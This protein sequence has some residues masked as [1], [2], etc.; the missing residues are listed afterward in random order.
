M[1]K[2]LVLS[3]ETM[4]KYWLQKIWIDWFNDSW[5]GLPNVCWLKDWG[6][7]DLMENNN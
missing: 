2:L 3:L 5:M 7:E 4:D 1:I 6:R